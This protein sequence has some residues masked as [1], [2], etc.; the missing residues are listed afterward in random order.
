MTSTAVILGTHATVLWGLDTRE[1][2]ERQCRAAGIERIVESA[3]AADDAGTVLL[4]DATCLFEVRTVNALLRR[5][6]TALLCPDDGRVA[7]IVAPAGEVAALAAYVGAAAAPAGL[8]A[9]M[10]DALE[11]YDRNLRKI[12]PPIVRRLDEAARD[13][14]ESL[15]YGSSY[16]GI[17][18]FVTKWWWPR[19]ARVVVGWCA[20]AR[21]TPNM[22]TSI[23]FV[24]MLLATV[25]FAH[26]W[27]LPGLVCAWVMTLLDTVDGKLARVT[28]T[29]SKIG[30]LFDHGIDLVHPPFWYVYWG[31]GL[32][33][34]ADIA[35]IPLGVLATAVVAGYVGGRVIEILFHQLGH[36]GIFAWR[37]FDAWFRLVTARRNPCLVLLTLGYLAGRAD[38]GYL[39]VV[40][41]TVLSTGVI[42]GRLLYAARERARSGPLDSWLRDPAHARAAWPR[43]FRTFTSTRAAYR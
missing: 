20:N 31:A 26:G 4:L 24:L 32:T 5:E 15:L 27:Y 9:L 33:T 23:G 30:H 29:S 6:R 37:P 11:G 36:C 34:G 28:V 13:A 17:T 1:R 8:D 10:P 25:L 43:T 7:A 35:G 12:E 42:L 14:L 16:K 2:I 40:A 39:A 19:P 18:D 3:D 38:L 21:M 22:I 41:W